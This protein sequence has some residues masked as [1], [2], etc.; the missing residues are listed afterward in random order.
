MAKYP[1]AELFE[2]FYQEVDSY[3]PGIQQGLKTLSSDRAALA[4]I[5]ELHRFFHNIKGAASQVQLFDLSNGAKVVESVLDGLL[6]NEQ[7]VSD[8]VLMALN[9]TADR[10]TEYSNNKKLD[11]DEGQIFHEQIVSLFAK[12]QQHSLREEYLHEVRLIFPLLQELAACLTEDGCNAGHDTIVYRKISHAVSIL[13]S[14][15]MAAGMQQQSQ[16][17][18]DFHLLLDMLQNEVSQERWAISGLIQDFL[19]FLEVIFAQDD[20]ENSTSVKKVKEQL[21]RLKALVAATDQREEGFTLAEET[22]VFDVLDIFDDSGTDGGSMDLLDEFGDLPFIEDAD[23]GEHDEVAALGAVEPLE[24]IFEKPEIDEEPMD[25]D[26]QLL[27]DIFRE[28]CEEH[29]IVINQTL[30]TL[31]NNVKEPSVLTPVLEASISDMRR[32]VHTLKGA[33]SMT[34]VNLLARGAHSLED[35]L[36][37]LH[38]EAGEINPQEVKVIATG[39]DIIELLSETPQAKESASL[40]NLVSAIDGYLAAKSQSTSTRDGSV[41]SAKEHPWEFVVEAADLK[42]KPNRN[43]V[44]KKQ[45]DT[46]KTPASL[47]GEMGT[48]RVRLED[49]DELVSIEG[50]LVV[51]RGALEKMV[52]E[53]SMALLELDNVKENLRRKS[54]ELESGFEVQSLY[55]FSPVGAQNRAGEPID[56]ELLDFDPIELDRYSQLNLIIRSLNEISVDVNSI[57]ATMESLK[58]EIGGQISKQQLTMRQMQDKLMRIRMTPLSSISRVL[59]RTVRDT[60]TKL[61]K[62]V[63]LTVTGEDVY[64]DRFVWAKITDPLMHILRNGVDHG[65]ESAEVRA[66][67]G[68]PEDATINLHAEQ[69]SRYVV[70]RISD[71]G[72]GV[73]FSLIKE[74]IKRQGLAEKPENLS[75]KE[76]LDYLFHSSFS[77]RQ[78]ITAISGRGVGLD[79]VRRNIQDLRG[80]IQIH[81]N[82]GQGVA[83]EIQIPF[84]L[85]VNRAALVSVAGKEFAVPLQDIVEVKHFSVK[86]IEDSEEP[87]LRFRGKSVPVSNLGYYLQLEK[88]V[89]TFATKPDG[90]LA[91]LSMTGDELSA[92]AIDSVSEQLEIIV[93]NIGSHLTQVRGISGVTLTG[94]GEIIPILN[95]RELL[96]VQATSDFW[97]REPSEYMELNEPLKVL[98]VD[99]SISVRHSVARL[100]ESQSWKQQQAVDGLDALAKLETFLPDVIILDIEMPRMNGYEFK[101]RINNQ[102]EYKDI[103]VVM[104]TS[105]ASEK[106]QQKARDLGIDHYLTKPYQ[107]ETFV[108][109]LENIRSDS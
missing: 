61:G 103:P 82:P 7:P 8:H 58:G 89:E 2:L 36:D 52:E 71:D 76:L 44:A 65:I 16:L 50:E 59:F 87:S 43:V 42:P 80:S 66:A 30:N 99:D 11:T 23:A 21:L 107:D 94:S 74:K 13:S 73:D 84:T 55:G 37:W 57:H 22:S 32:A 100:V 93:K 109:L 97:V 12:N 1:N 28:E 62:K 17:M 90:V 51:A 88:K 6:E 72:A 70:L 54:Q 39:I 34:G 85:S 98:I 27:M 56:N 106:H 5:E 40:D 26:Q 105:R 83:F 95:L 41:Q 75:E 10:L 92:V 91:I 68:K 19:C 69:R 101:S 46:D 20:P 77:T 31:E 45:V 86:E 48:V 81:N 78:N 9:Q 60:A 49:L 47:P 3:I 96:D 38:D 15:V 63:A 53:F 24:P 67:V 108:R 104:L 14:T 35:L 64:M 102:P 79:V 4:A 33:A 29:L 18:Q 25:E